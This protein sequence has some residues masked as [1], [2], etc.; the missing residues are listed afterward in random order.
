[1]KRFT[2]D[3]TIDSDEERMNKVKEYIDSLSVEEY[4]ELAEKTEYVDKLG[5]YV[6]FAYDKEMKKQKEHITPAQHR[7]L[8]DNENGIRSN[9]DNRHSRVHVKKDKV[10]MSEEN[11]DRVWRCKDDI[12]LV[13]SQIEDYRK[14]LENNNINSKQKETIY[15]DIADCKKALD[16]CEVKT[17]DDSSRHDVLNEVDWEYNVKTI[18]IFL[19]HYMDLMTAEPYSMKHCIYIDL[20]R[21]MKEC[22]F[23]DKQHIALEDYM[24][25]ISFELIDTRT[26]N[27]AVE[28]IL[29]KL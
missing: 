22:K 13:L 14:L 18:K 26:L 23:T 20:D 15:Q 29:K 8:I 25:G 3:Y 2:F 17:H 5:E 4:E 11:V 24:N 1:M 16:I 21:A 10:P 6:L 12:E 9:I 7:V 28:K 27:C 19:R